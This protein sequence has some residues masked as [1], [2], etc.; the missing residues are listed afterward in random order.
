MS[1][2]IE[3]ETKVIDEKLISYI[4]DSVSSV[5]KTY[6]NLTLEDNLNNIRSIAYFNDST[7][8][9][10]II[11]YSEERFP[12]TGEVHYIKKILSFELKNG[13][14]VMDVL[15]I[16][17]FSHSSENQYNRH[18]NIYQAVSMNFH[19]FSDDILMME[20][21]NSFNSTMNYTSIINFEKN[22]H[23]VYIF[24]AHKIEKYEIVKDPKSK[25][26]S[27][28]MIKK[29]DLDD[30]LLKKYNDNV[31]NYRYQNF[32]STSYIRI[33][34][35]LSKNIIMFAAVIFREGSNNISRELFTNQ[36]HLVFYDFDKMKVIRI[37]EGYCYNH[38]Y[39]NII[40]QQMIIL[41]GL[42]N[43]ILYDFMNNVEVNQFANNF[44]A[45]DQFKIHN[46]PNYRLQ[47]FMQ[48][49]VIII[50][51]IYEGNE[52]REDIFRIIDEDYIPEHERCTVCNI[53]RME[54]NKIFSCG[55][56]VSSCNSCIDDVCTVCEK[57]GIVIELLF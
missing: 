37:F 10:Y 45:G 46:N 31:S 50:S 54:L 7:T 16:E 49:P 22:G 44:K 35:H 40:N 57:K 42:S 47:I 53:F 23:N 33:G 13:D 3:Y 32:S 55:H 21:Q 41:S 5:R 25:R 27:F 24:S 6:P 2:L 9:Y 14:D 56:K 29:Y 43:H 34:R 18:L 36:N 1:D 12:M 4:T 17:S 15:L 11:K 39:P 26:Y 20:C 8:M 51:S 28:R 30:S 19:E 48:S 38:L 52:Y